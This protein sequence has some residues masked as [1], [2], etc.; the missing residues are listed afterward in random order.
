MRSRDKYHALLAKLRECTNYCP[1]CSGEYVHAG[2]CPLEG[3][4]FT[5]DCDTDEQ[6]VT[7]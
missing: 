6:E 4:W 5:D 2:D 7:G 3:D 1:Y